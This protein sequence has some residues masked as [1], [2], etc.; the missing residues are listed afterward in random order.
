MIVCGRDYPTVSN[1]VVYLRAGTIIS[2]ERR[3]RGIGTTKTQSQL[4]APLNIR[5]ETFCF[6]EGKE[7]EKK[8]LYRNVGLF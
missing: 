4:Y 2:S 1:D 6:S 5:E 8:N 7:K 3:K